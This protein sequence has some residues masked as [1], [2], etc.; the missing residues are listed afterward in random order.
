M[1]LA[2]GG[3][4][5]KALLDPVNEP[6][7]PE[8]NYYQNAK[9]LGVHDMWQLHTARTNLCKEYLDRWNESGIDALLCKNLF[10]W[11][12]PPCFLLTS[13]TGPT[14]PYASIEHGNFK[15]VG[16]T[17]VFN[18]LDYSA[19]SFPTGLCAHEEHDSAHDGEPLNATC[20]EVRQSCKFS[21]TMLLS[22]S[23]DM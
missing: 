9:E 4:S 6:W 14:S 5:V 10:S 12:M 19:A 8:M 23:A 21:S 20:D 15:Y 17:G 7:R 18:I 2:D 22:N 11:H 13:C 1:F 3:K 16:Y